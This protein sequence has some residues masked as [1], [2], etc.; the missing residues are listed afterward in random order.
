[1][2][3]NQNDPGWRAEGG[4]VV[5]EGGLLGARVPAGRGTLTFVYRPRSFVVGSAVSLATLVLAGAFHMW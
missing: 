4:E 1:V 3:V 5:N 2:L